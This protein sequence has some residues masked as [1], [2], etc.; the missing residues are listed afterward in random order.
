[1]WP[2]ASYIGSGWVGFIFGNFIYPY[3]AIPINFTPLL[4][5]NFYIPEANPLSTITASVLKA[6]RT[7]PA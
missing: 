4:N 2:F 1:M 6:A 7:I 3:G 5:A